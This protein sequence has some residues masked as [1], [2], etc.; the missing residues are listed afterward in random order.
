MGSFPEPTRRHLERLPDR[1]FLSFRRAA[2]CQVIGLPGHHG[3]LQGPGSFPAPG[4][5]PPRVLTD[6]PAEA[7]A[8]V[9]EAWPRP[10][11]ALHVGADSPEPG[12]LLRLWSL[13]PEFQN[14]PPSMEK[15]L[16]GAS[17]G[18]CPGG[19]RA[20]QGGWAANTLERGSDSFGAAPQFWSSGHPR[21]S[22][23][24]WDNSGAFCPGTSGPRCCPEAAPPG[25]W[26]AGSG[27]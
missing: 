4:P 8:P 21:S 2:F 15:G 9:L 5:P 10:H 17:S 22:E 20:P 27:L 7:G 12:G 19:R 23:A 6:G 25:E 14:H 13:Q 11:A 16:Q 3:A 24:A 1:V 18:W 26:W